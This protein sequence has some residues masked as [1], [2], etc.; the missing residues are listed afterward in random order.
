MPSPTEVS[1]A[2]RECSSRND[3]MSRIPADGLLVSQSSKVSAVAARQVN[4][5]RPSL[6]PIY[7][8]QTRHILL[9]YSRLE[10]D[11]VSTLLKQLSGRRFGCFPNG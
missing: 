5:P 2:S 4:A 1:A 8:R 6:S 10:S 9:A 7:D 11:A 3:K